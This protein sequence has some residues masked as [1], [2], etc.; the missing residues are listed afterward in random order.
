MSAS[1]PVVADDQSVAERYFQ[2][3]RM[4]DR[5][6][7]RHLDML[8]FELEAPGVGRYKCSSGSDADRNARPIDQRARSD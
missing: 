2:I 5:L 3:T 7:R 4:I 6:H 8:R 1:I